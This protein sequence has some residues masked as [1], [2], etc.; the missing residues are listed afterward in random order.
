[1]NRVY[2]V[3][4]FGISEE[5]KTVDLCHTEE[6][7]RRMTV[8]QLRQKVVEKFPGQSEGDLRMIFTDKFM[9]DDSSLVC[10]Y[11]IQHKSVIRLVLRVPGGLAA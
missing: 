2:Q 7:M 3:Q 5:V 6:Q 10:E 8:L 4:V 11:G 1:M 9:D